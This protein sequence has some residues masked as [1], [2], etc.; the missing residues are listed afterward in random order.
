MTIDDDPRVSGIFS[1]MGVFA[2]IRPLK[3]AAGVGICNVSLSHPRVQDL[4]LKGDFIIPALILIAC[5][6]H[7][8]AA[9]Q[10]PL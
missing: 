7:L 4:I 10:P 6:A 9:A 3:L 1:N 5:L 8:I 2:D